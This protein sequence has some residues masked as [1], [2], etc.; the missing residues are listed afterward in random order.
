MEMSTLPLFPNLA[1]P[2]LA[3][4][5]LVLLVP[6]VAPALGAVGRPAAYFFLIAV[7]GLFVAQALGLARWTYPFVDWTMYT[8]ADFDSATWVVELERESGVREARGRLLPHRGME[9][10][11]LYWRAYLLA[12]THVSPD[13]AVSPDA[14]ADALAR[15]TE[16]FQAVDLA[17]GRALGPGRDRLQGASLVKCDAL[18]ALG[19]GREGLACDPDTRIRIELGRGTP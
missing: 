2:L 9:N 16:F 4:V 15:L 3:V 10:R 5:V 11:A 18:G 17:E 7:L 6:R 19:V 1:Y 12:H 14:R 8:R 13:T